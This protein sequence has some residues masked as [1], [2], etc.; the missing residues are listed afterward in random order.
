MMEFG[1]ARQLPW[2]GRPPWRFA[3]GIL[4]VHYCREYLAYMM[5]F[6]RLK[7][8]FFPPHGGSFQLAIL[9]KG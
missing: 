2:W 9:D 1:V 3:G 8:A 5:G 4:G 7:I 6:S